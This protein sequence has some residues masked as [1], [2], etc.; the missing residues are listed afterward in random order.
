MDS[1]SEGKTVQ[2]NGMVNGIKG[3]R[4]VEETETGDLL[5]TNGI[6]KMIAKRKKCSLN[7]MKFAVSRLEEI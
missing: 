5:A 1:K 7:R 4:E 3:C 6:D 2:E